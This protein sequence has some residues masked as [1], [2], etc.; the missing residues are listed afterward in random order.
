MSGG[1]FI[2]YLC[3]VFY[4]KNKVIF[5]QWSSDGVCNTM[6]WLF[7]LHW[8]KWYLII[9]GEWKELIIFLHVLTL[10]SDCFKCLEVLI[11]NSITIAIDLE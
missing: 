6:R 8:G 9:N 3:S 10:W 7:N 11:N 1:S 5:Q 2:K 4:Q